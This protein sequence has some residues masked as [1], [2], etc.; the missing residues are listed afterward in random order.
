MERKYARDLADL[1]VVVNS[2]EN[3]KEGKGKIQKPSFGEWRCD[4]YVLSLQVCAQ[5]ICIRKG[6]RRETLNLASGEGERF[7]KESAE[8]KDNCE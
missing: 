6:K 5:A 7:Q 4:I 2:S 3:C 8:E 1:V